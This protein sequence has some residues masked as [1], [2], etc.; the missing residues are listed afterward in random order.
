MVTSNFNY[1]S[2]IIAHEIGRGTLTAAREKLG[3]KSIQMQWKVHI[4]RIALYSFC[5]VLTE[6]VCEFPKTK[7]QVCKPEF[8]LYPEATWKTSMVRLFQVKY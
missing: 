7:P 8:A 2:T 4:T 5:K 3:S 6:S 1:L